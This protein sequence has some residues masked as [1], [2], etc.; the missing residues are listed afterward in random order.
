MIRR[1]PRST[2]FPYTTLFRSAGRRAAVAALDVGHRP[3]PRLHAVEEVADVGPELVADLLVAI[4]LD[5]LRPQSPRAF[6]G[7]PRL[8]AELR[9]LLFG[10]DLGVGDH[11]EA[12]PVDAQRAFGPPELQAAPVTGRDLAVRPG[13]DEGRVLEEGLEH[14]GGLPEPAQ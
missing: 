6:P 4:V 13:R 3:R 2:L 7:P 10:G 9:D 5:G 8:L 14:V 11:F 12:R 1:P